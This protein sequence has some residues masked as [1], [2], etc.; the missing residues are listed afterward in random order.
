MAERI[1][2]VQ[3]STPDRLLTVDG[4][5]VEF[6]VKRQD[7]GEPAEGTVTVWNLSR[8]HRALLR[9]AKRVTLMPQGEV[10]FDA[11]VER[12][13]ETY[14]GQDIGFAVHAR[15]GSKALQTYVG[16]SYAGGLP[17]TAA[18]ILTDTLGACGITDSTVLV[19]LPGLVY[20]RGKMLYGEAWRII[21]T[22][23]RSLGAYWEVQ[24]GKLFMW[25]RGTALQT[26]V[27]LDAATGL[28]G[29]PER[30]D[31]NEELRRANPDTSRTRVNTY[32][33]R[34]LLA[35]RVRPG[36]VL[37]VVSRSV[38]GTLRVR[39][40]RAYGDTRGNDWYT[41]AEAELAA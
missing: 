22:I 24:D 29:T 9:S 10:L 34:M 19:D 17:V 35:P 27:H 3:F 11:D 31:D 28:V 8:D 33:V 7:D 6:D 41:E 1:C 18:T 37:E 14:A 12:Y 25:P 23:A 26:F 40:V 30:I 38:T 4:L 39:S 16:R 20:R 2:Q 5:R 32:R 15:D 36:A 21:D 13:T